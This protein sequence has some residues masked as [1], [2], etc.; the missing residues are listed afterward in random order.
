MLTR[1]TSLLVC[2]LFAVS[3]TK[4]PEN[5]T[6]PAGDPA[7]DNLKAGSLTTVSF[8]GYTWYVKN[9]TGMGPGY[10]NWNPANVAVVNGKLQLT[11]TYNTVTGKWDCAEVWTTRNLGF[12]T[13]EWEVEGELDQLHQNVVLGLFN[14]LPTATQGGKKT[15]EIDIEFSKWGGAVTNIGGFTVW[16]NKTNLAEWTIRFPSDFDATH[17][18]SRH[19]FKWSSKSVSFSSSDGF[20][21][22]ASSTYSPLVTPTYYIPQLAQPVHM[23]LWVFGTVS[24]TSNNS[25]IGGAAT[26]TITISNFKFTKGSR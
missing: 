14:Y 8:A 19:S 10:N 17:K 12:G 18:V 3:C 22:P 23:N 20:G 15:A 5:S 7:A 24:G 13:Y 2:I 4:E 6:V 9:A 25:I 1:V 21:T 16:P 26:A 11:L